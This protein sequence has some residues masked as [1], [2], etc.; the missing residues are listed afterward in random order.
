MKIHSGTLYFPGEPDI[1]ADQV[2]T[3]VLLEKFNQSSMTELEK[4]A[5]YLRETFV[6]IDEKCYI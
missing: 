3:L 5:Q 6:E 4:Q 2:Q 1:W